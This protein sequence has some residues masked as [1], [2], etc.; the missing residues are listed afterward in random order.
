MTLLSRYIFN[1][2]STIWALFLGILTQIL[3]LLALSNPVLAQ[4]WG[5]QGRVFLKNQNKG[6]EFASVALLKTSDSAL[7]TGSLTRSG[8]YFGLDKVQPGRYLLE[9]RFLGCTPL[10]RSVQVIPSVPATEVGNLYLEED[11]TKLQTVEITDSRQ[12]TVLGIDRKVYTV[13]KDLTSRGAS[14]L[15]VMRNLPGVTTDADGTVRLRNAVPQIFVDGRPSV[16]TLEQIP[17]E[18]I[19]RI[20]V[21]TNPSVRFDANTTGGLLNVVLKRAGGPGY[22]GSANAGLGTGNRWNTGLNLNLKEGASAWSVSYNF[23]DFYNP[24]SNRTLRQNLRDGQATETFFQVSEGMLGRRFQMGRLAWDYTLNQR[25]TLTASFNLGDGRFRNYDNQPYTWKS[26]APNNSSLT[27]VDGRQTNQQQNFWRYGSLQFLLRRTTAKPGEEWSVDLNL[28]QSANGTSADLNNQ[29]DSVLVN[30]FF[31]RLQENQGS[32]QN[33]VY[34]AQY[35]HT[36]PVEN[37]KWEWG[38]RSNLRH[39]RSELSVRLGLNGAVPT[40]DSN[41]SNAFEIRDIINAA[42]L[43]RQLRWGNW[44]L[45]AGLRIEQTLFEV[46]LP[47]LG[48]SSFAYRYPNRGQQWG[49]AMFPALFLSRKHGMHEWQVN[50]SRKIGRPGFFQVLPFILF[51]DAQGYR[52]GNPALAP[53]FFHLAE[54]NHQYTSGTTSLTSSLFGR[55]TT[56]VITEF[57]S[58]LTQDSTLLVNSYLNGDR[59]WSTG[60][61]ES[62]RWNP[63]KVWTLTSNVNVFYTDVNAGASMNNLRQGGWSW[64]AKSQLAYRPNQQWSVQWNG[65]YEA[66]RVLPQGRTYPAYGMDLSAS[67]NPNK[68]WTL[69]VLLSDLANTRRFGNTVQTETLFQEFIRRREVRFLR[70]TLTYRFGNSDA[71]LF[72]KMRRG[73]PPAGGGGDMG[74]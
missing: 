60:W 41:L 26:P 15:E 7:V 3:G 35:D 12:T 42:Y 20:E 28:N 47:W 33:Q 67:W 2:R 46:T 14:A 72:Q 39:N 10:Y 9:V 51:A 58:R 66:P 13:D 18:Q 25:T 68:S 69:V 23:S 59:Q 50:L 30:K 56:Q 37:G 17:A 24:L 61:E 32:G 45:Q 19:E 36:R 65:E 54:I 64:T 53:E 44:G 48:D 43:N 21:M 5:I 38:L 55:Y 1:A 62:F 70:L 29:A 16:L 22:Q 4:N 27:L 63:S 49:N 73:G 74:F 34:T 52:I 57:V 6:L 40:M 31:S 71:S 11:V 8:G